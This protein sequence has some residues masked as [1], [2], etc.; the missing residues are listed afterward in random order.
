MQESNFPYIKSLI[1]NDCYA[2]QGL[3]ID[4]N[5]PEG[6]FKHIILTGKNG[7]GKTTILNR[8]E[9]FVN[10]L[11]QGVLPSDQINYYNQ[12]IKQNPKSPDVKTWEKE[13]QKMSGVDIQYT[14][15]EQL[16]KGNKSFLFS[17]FRASRKVDVK[18]VNTVSKETDFLTQLNNTNNSTEFFIQNFKQY[19]VNKKVYQAFAQLGGKQEEIA[20]NE[21]FFERFTETL[22]SVFHDQK[23][24]LEFE[25]EN[26]EFFLRLG[27][28]RRITF[29]ELSDGFSAF[30][31]ILMDLFMRVDLL[32]KEKQDFAYNPAGFVLI[33]E[34]ETHFHISMQYEVL[35]IIANLFPNLQM[36]VATHSPA[37]ISSLKDAVVYDLSSQKQVADWLL[38]SSYSELMIKHFGL[39][40]EFSPVADHILE[41]VSEAVKAKNPAKLKQIFVENEQYLTPSLRLEIESQLIELQASI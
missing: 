41:D 24:T 15:K 6:G 38:G 39:E 34:P 37:V 10:V 28:G 19:L 26:F 40:N 29:N 14:Q 5:P 20:E 22:R 1:I 13:L 35:P 17:F 31:H 11:K 21:R 8:I 32:R 12:V 33:D 30:L 9:L 36:I 25:Q 18:Q 7:S 3:R 27:D 16:L 23:L 4:T 2:Y